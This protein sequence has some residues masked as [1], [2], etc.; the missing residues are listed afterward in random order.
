MKVCLISGTWSGMRCGVGDYTARLAQALSDQGEQ[1]MVLTSRGADLEAS[2]GVRGVMKTWSLRG[3]WRLLRELARLRP[4]LV[5][6]Q[7]PTSAYGRGAAV[8]LL[9]PLAALF[10]PRMRR[11][12]TLHEY[13]MYSFWGRLRLRGVLAGAQ[14]VICTNRQDRRCL[15]EER[16]AA[17]KIIRVIPL[18]SNVGPDRPGGGFAHGSVRPLGEGTIWLLIFG[19]LT[20][21]KGWESLLTAL[22]R[23]RAQGREIGVRFLGELLPAGH[24][25]HRRL[26]ER[27]RDCDLEDAIR[28][29]GYLSPERIGTLVRVSSGIAVLP[30]TGGASLNRGSL[31]AMLAHGLAVITTQPARRLE[32]LVHGRH[33][34][35][36]EPDSPDALADGICRVLDDPALAVRLQAGARVA[37]DRF[38]WPRIATLTRRVY[39]KLAETGENGQ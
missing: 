16:S 24:P 8:I 15:R 14:A 2:P 25:F 32:G 6:V 38:A 26:A 9:L 1:V 22:Q 39:A 23:L 4:D 27:I 13:G 18:G 10:F 35:G 33:Y 34:W 30:Y 12:V 29:T 28:S 5:H 37:A 17:R 19:T 21:N 11:V 3:V 7:Y 36:V 31:V 20:A